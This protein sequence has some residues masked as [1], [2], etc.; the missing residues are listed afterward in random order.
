[1]PFPSDTAVRVR[2]ARPEEASALGELALRSKGHWGYDEAFLAACRDELAVR[3]EDL[4]SGDATVA[5]DDAGRIL[6]FVLV[7][8]APPEGRLDMLFVDPP[9]I[10]S[11]LGRRLFAEAL[12]TARRLGM[13]RLTIDADPYA[14]PFYRAMGARVTGTVPSGSVPGRV[15]PLMAVDVPSPLTAAGL[16][17]TGPLPR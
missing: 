13:R 9:A 4:A 7:D 2:P 15:L 11:G 3:P 17:S 5:E 10:G 1:M 6:G 14:E 16:P 12:S 8:G